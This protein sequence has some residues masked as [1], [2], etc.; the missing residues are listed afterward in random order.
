MKYIII[1]FFESVIR[2]SKNPT[3]KFDPNL[4][5]DVLILLIVRQLIMRIRG[6]KLLLRGRYVSSIQLGRNVSFRNFKKIKLGSGV[7]I[8]D[9]TYIDALGKNF[10]EI[11]DYCSLGAYSRLITSTSYNQL[12]EGIVLGSNVGIGEWAYIGGAGGVSIGSDTIAGQFLSIHPENHVTDQTSKL[13]RLQGVTRIGITIG[14]NV[15]IGAK[16]TI[17]DGVEIGDGSIISAGSLVTKGKYPKNAV[18]GGVPA[19]LIKNR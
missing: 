2:R 16:V 14:K 8:D 17:L 10:I 11:G 9:Y 5:L 15:W 19:K 18:L 3:F 13:I 4:S 7:K 6:L 12:G 1:K